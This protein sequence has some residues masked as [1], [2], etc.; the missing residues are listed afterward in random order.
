LDTLLDS[1]H[2]VEAPCVKRTLKENAKHPLRQEA[3]NS[4]VDETK[5]LIMRR[6][7]AKPIGRLT[8]Q[9]FSRS[10]QE[11]PF[12]LADL[13]AGG[14]DGCKPLLASLMNFSGRNKL[15]TEMSSST[16]SQ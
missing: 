14:A 10:E 11:S 15:A 5:R 4:R 8:T 3:T 1:D 16:S 2:W 7:I 12:G 13:L 9:A 6:S